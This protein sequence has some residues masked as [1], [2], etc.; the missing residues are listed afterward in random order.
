M[1][2]TTN[3]TWAIQCQNGYTP[4]DPLNITCRYS[5]Y[6]YGWDPDPSSLCIELEGI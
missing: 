6:N 2:T 5:N 1:N 3:S 4:I